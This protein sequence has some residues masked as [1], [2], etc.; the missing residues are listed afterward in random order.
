MWEPL[1]CRGFYVILISV[2]FC[3]FTR[4][5]VA[6]QAYMDSNE[7]RDGYVTVSD[8]MPAGVPGGIC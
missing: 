4:E 2:A 1:S 3:Q 5:T 7:K 6:G 8:C